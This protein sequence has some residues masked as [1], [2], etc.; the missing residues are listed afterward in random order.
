MP[1]PV[2]VFITGPP[3]AGKTTVG[4]AWAESQPKAAAVDQDVVRRFI[5]GGFADAVKAWDAD[6]RWQW[7]LAREL[8][9]GL[10]RRYLDEGFD[11]L[12][13]APCAPRVPGNTYEDWQILLDG[14]P[15]VG[16]IVLL[17]DLATVQVRMAGRTGPKKIPPPI[18]EQL[19]YPITLTWR[20][21]PGAHLIDNSAMTVQETLDA[22][23]A[24]ISA[25]RS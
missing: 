23:S 20:D 3:G 15:V 18:V 25:A 16:P 17:P 10:A 11:C 22:V 21:E 2:V 1:G 8:C 5:K 14:L 13:D 6:V 4:Q 24:F 19:L 7:A 12:I 9:V